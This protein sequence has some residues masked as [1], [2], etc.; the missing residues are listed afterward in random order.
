MSENHPTKEKLIQTFL[1][2]SH[3]HNWHDITSDMVLE[4][5]NITKGSL[6]HHFQDFGELEE[7]VRVRRFSNW[8]DESIETLMGHLSRATSKEE[9]L[10]MVLEYTKYSQSSTRAPFRLERTETITMTRNNKRLAEKLSKE[11]DRLTNSLTDIFREAQEKGFINK[12]IDP[13]II[14]VFVQAY[15]IGKVVDDISSTPMNED[16]WVKLIY[17]IF[18]KVLI[19]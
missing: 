4:T 7:T 15:T 1:D 3:T 9:I 12:N 18:N 19:A 14:A 16:N 5:S 11:Q 6:Y 8:V 10:K 2:L 13:K 17:E